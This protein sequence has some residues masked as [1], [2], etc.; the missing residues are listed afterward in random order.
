[1]ITPETLGR[2]GRL[3]DVDP[4]LL[5]VG[6][7]GEPAIVVSALRAGL[8][9]TLASH[10]DLDA[11]RPWASVTKLATALAAAI[12][13]EDGR[14]RLD[15]AVGPEGS[16]LAHLMSH[17]SGLGFEASDPV[18]APAT[19]RI[20]SNYGIDLAATHLSAGTDLATWLDRRVVAP[21]SMTSTHLVGRASE[22]LFGSTRD[23]AAFAREW[24][25][26]TLVSAHRRDVTATAY[27]PELAGIVPGFGRFTPCPW[28]L[29]VEIR[30]EKQHWMGDWP[31]R[32]F[33]HF[34]RSGALALVSVDEGLCVVATST[35]EFGPWAHDLWPTWTSNVR[36]FA[37]AS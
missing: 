17:S 34:G 8:W 10:G 2:P 35:V 6:W 7:S 15:D 22:G 16:T 28:G 4:S 19:K 3:D 29:G 14:A 30:G 21:L 36:Q 11:V 24:I 33:G 1:M 18:V 23:L 5:A 12:D 27:L 32:S 9:H 31:A 37:G 13:V 25:A 20:Y 26:P